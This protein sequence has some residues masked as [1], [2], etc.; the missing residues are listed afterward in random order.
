MT[1]ERNKAISRRWH[2]AWGTS[3][4][5]SVYAECLAPDFR[6]LFFGQGWVNRETYIER[7]QAFLGAFADVEIAVEVAVGE[8]DLVLCRMRWRGRQTGEILEIPATGREF[9]IMGFAQD[10]FRD[11]WVVE[12]IP[13]FDQASLLAQLQAKRAF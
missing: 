5:P 7:D 2:E 4:L 11:G 3:D 9:E 8:G 10:R 12:H 6:A 13:L 1:I